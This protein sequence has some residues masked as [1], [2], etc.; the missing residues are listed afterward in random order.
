MRTFA[1]P[2]LGEGSGSTAARGL[3]HRVAIFYF[4]KYH[5]CFNPLITFLARLLKLILYFVIFN[6]IYKLIILSIIQILA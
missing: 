5:Y 6:N 3:L 1:G 4:F 2:Y